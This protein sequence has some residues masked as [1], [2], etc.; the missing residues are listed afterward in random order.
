MKRLLV[1]MLI[2]VAVGLVSASAF[3][4]VVTAS[5]KSNTYILVSIGAPGGDYSMHTMLSPG[6]CCNLLGYTGLPYNIKAEVL[7]FPDF[8]PTGRYEIKTLTLKWGSH[9]D[10]LVRFYF[11]GLTPVWP[12]FPEEPK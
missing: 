6:S 8:M 2:L 12:V 1:I 5:N 7:S 4:A 10:N 3:D 9:P 11:N